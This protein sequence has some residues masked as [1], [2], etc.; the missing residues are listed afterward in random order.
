MTGHVI[1]WIR[2][3]V[4]TNQGAVEKKKDRETRYRCFEQ[5]H[6]Y[7]EVS[8]AALAEWNKE[9]NSQYN[10]AEVGTKWRQARKWT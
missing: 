9:T 4:Q 2:Y 3:Q 5:E 1:P 7:R 8:G 10:R 6:P